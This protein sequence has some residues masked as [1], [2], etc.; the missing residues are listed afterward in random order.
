MACPRD[1]SP[2]AAHRDR[3]FRPWHLG[4]YRIIGTKEKRPE[5]GN[6]FFFDLMI[7]QLGE[8]LIEN[9]EILVTSVPTRYAAP[10]SR[11]E[12]TSR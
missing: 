5:D 11:L 8:E 7:A 6:T 9:Q 3:L 2:P 12:R 10:T 1:F 4:N